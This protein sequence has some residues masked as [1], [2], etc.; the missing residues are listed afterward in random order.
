[1]DELIIDT[2][3][4]ILY[5]V[6]LL[7]AGY[8]VSKKH[9]KDSADEFLT[10][11]KHLNWFET[12]L[13][14]IAMSIDTGIMGVAGIGFVWG[15]AIQPNAVNLWISA[16]IAAMFLI[17]I[18]WRTKIVTTPEL[19]EKRFNVASRAF[20]SVIMSANNVIIMGTSIYLGGLIL[21][22]IF[23]WNIQ[24]GSI[25]IMAVTG[26]YVMMGG[27][28][29]VL[30]INIYQSV[31]IVL[32]LIT[33]GVM[34]V[35]QVG[36]I[37]EFMAITEVSKSGAELLSTKL[38][39]DFD[40]FSKLWFPAPAG[41]VWAAMAGS[42]WI[43]CN[44]AMVQRLL[45]AKNEKHAQKAIL[46][47]GFGHVFTFFI[48]YVIGIS[49]RVLSPN[50]LPD[51]SY[52]NAI[53]DFFPVG[54]RGLLIAGLIASLIS[55]ID[56]LLTSTGTLITK[57]IYLR[58]VNPKSSD[59]RTKRFTRII[60]GSA[61]LIAIFLILPFAL[62]S[63]TITAFIQGLVADLF[64]VVISLFLVGIFSTRATSKAAFASMLIGITAT[65]LIDVYTEINFV[66]IGIFSFTITTV[67]VLVLSL[68]EKP[69]S[70]EELKN[71]TVF[72]LEGTKAPWV[73][74]KSWPQ[75][76]TW[77]FAIIVGWWGLTFLWE[78]LVTTL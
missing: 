1:M 24:L 33:V 15:L 70:R 55:T 50:I 77:I 60:Q 30:S 64:G 22:E 56:G 10:G 45:A 11:G 76:G 48:A 14:V 78:W 8:F 38:P 27:M 46:F 75:L 51:T 29:T 40:L 57:D 26:I 36:G 9:A 44:F 7:L 71:L 13:T 5:F 41:F 4:V 59:K 66:N 3:V 34:C 20:F 28:K 32:T 47:S 39:T 49:M 63:E 25:A 42:A 67:L 68:F 35:V 52:I 37:S 6:I 74:L 54:I 19:L 16:P 12:A 61:I 72:T 2:G 53:M 17:P 43:A 23:D 62:E 58:F 69:K 21:S 73:G 18:Y 31:F 65:V